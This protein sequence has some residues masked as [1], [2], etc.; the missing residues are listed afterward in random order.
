MIIW[1]KGQQFAKKKLPI[2]VKC[3]SFCSLGVESLILRIF[4]TSF[5]ISTCAE[6]NKDPSE[7]RGSQC[8][9]HRHNSSEKN[10]PI[11]WF[12]DDPRCSKDF[13]IIVVLCNTNLVITLKSVNS[14]AVV[15]LKNGIPWSSVFSVVLELKCEEK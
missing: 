15:A 13:L 11:W 6:P 1:T 7:N 8:E 3:V 9:F 12:Y 4:C 14:L 10:L 5:S 2:W